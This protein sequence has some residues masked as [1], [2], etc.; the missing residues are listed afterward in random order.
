MQKI[1]KKVLGGTPYEF[2]EEVGLK[3]EVRF[4]EELRKELKN[5]E[6][7]EKI[8]KKKIKGVG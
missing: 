3:E 5:W 6:E 8:K 1:K 7:K 2:R 4:E